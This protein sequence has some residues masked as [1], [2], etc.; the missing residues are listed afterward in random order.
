MQTKAERD[1]GARLPNLD[2][3][4]IA[5][6]IL[7]HI[8]QVPTASTRAIR[9]SSLASLGRWSNAGKRSASDVVSDDPNSEGTQ[10]D[11][12][13]AGAAAPAAKRSRRV[14]KPGQAPKS[15]AGAGKSTGASSSKGSLDTQLASALHAAT[16]SVADD[17]KPL[18][19]FSPDDATIDGILQDLE[20]EMP[21]GVKGGASGTM[22]EGGVAAPY[23]GFVNGAYFGGAGV[24]RRSPADARPGR[25]NV[26]LGSQ[27]RDSYSPLFSGIRM[28]PGARSTSFT[29]D[30][31]GDL[32][33]PSQAMFLGDAS[34]DHTSG[35]APQQYADFTQFGGSGFATHEARHASPAEMDGAA[36]CASGSINSSSPHGSPPRP[37]NL[38]IT[39]TAH[40]MPHGLAGT[41][42]TAAAV[43]VTPPEVGC[44]SHTSCTSLSS[45]ATQPSLA[46]APASTYGSAPNAAPATAAP[47]PKAPK[48]ERSEGGGNSNSTSA[49]GNR[50]EWSAWEDETIRNGVLQ[51]GSRWRVIAAELPG[52]SDD[53]VRNRWARLQQTITA[54]NGVKPPSAPRVRR[55]GG[56]QR[57]SWTAEEDEIISSSV[58]EFGHRWNRIAE[59]LPR[60]TEH[61]IRNRWHRL[62]MRSLEGLEGL[63]A[64]GVSSPRIT[65]LIK[66]LTP[67]GKTAMPPASLP[68]RAP[69][70]SA[71]PA[72]PMTAPTAVTSV[73]APAPAAAVLPTVGRPGPM[74]LG[75]AE[76]LEEA[77]GLVEVDGSAATTVEEE[78]GELSSGFDFDSVM[79]L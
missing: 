69:T 54:P 7:G 77:R 72:A 56:E 4:S 79:A 32:N 65:P 17:S 39:V 76:G 20:G 10:S 46:P 47:A 33:H 44:S 38:P 30:Q 42:P 3:T 62:Q 23:A 51:L 40:T 14:A 71:P 26:F 57:Q 27:E 70:V 6:S 8:M 21:S 63:G 9:A 45:L 68:V 50:K 64:E 12:E 43:L 67:A 24:P 41:I 59:R 1:R 15:K 2:T 11:T 25:D 19:G 78:L 58:L 52:R 16:S 18:P 74:L 37:C 22:M 60:R 28:E 29:L 35:G 34:I 49:D 75:Q 36:S 73:P 48:K 13:S 61:A 55:E 53:A 5:R 31:I 66:T